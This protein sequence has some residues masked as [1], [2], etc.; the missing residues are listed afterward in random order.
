MKKATLSQ[1]IKSLNKFSAILSEKNLLCLQSMIS[2]RGGDGDE[3]I[4]IPPPP[5]NP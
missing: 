4:I 1:E 2:V 3:P 5:K